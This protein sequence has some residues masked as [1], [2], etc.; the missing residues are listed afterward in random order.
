ML[1]GK[2]PGGIYK[3]SREAILTAELPSRFTT[4]VNQRSSLPRDILS[5]F[6]LQHRLSEPVFSIIS[7]PFKIPTES[8]ESI[9]KAAN[10]GT[11][12]IE[13]A[14][15]ASVNACQKKSY[16]EIFKYGIKLLSR[17]KD[18]MILCFPK[19]CYKK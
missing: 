18:L 7:H 16:S 5:I 12:L 13:C 1:L 19:D 8:S 9:F 4:R 6:C 2:T 15:G 10:L 3:L 14:N 17:C 11:N